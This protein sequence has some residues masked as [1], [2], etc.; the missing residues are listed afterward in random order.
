MATIKMKV[1][2]L[3]LVIFTL[4]LCANRGQSQKP[5]SLI[6]F[7]NIPSL[8]N[9]ALS[10]DGTQLV[11]V[12][13][14]SNWEKNRQLGHI[15]RQNVDGTNLIQL[16]NSPEGES[17]PQWSP[18]GKYISFISKRDSDEENQ[19]YLI[20]NIG[21]E[22]KRLSDHPTDVRNIQ[23][24]PDA[25]SI[26]FIANEKKSR[27]EKKRDKLKDDVFAFDENYKH[28]HLWRLA[29]TDSSATRITEGEFS[30]GSYELSKDGGSITFS[31]RPSPLLDD[32][33]NSEI[34]TMSNNGQNPR[35]L[36]FNSIPE[37]A[38]KLSFDGK[39]IIFIAGVNDKFE[40]YYDDNLFIL[41]VDGGLAELHLAD[42]NYE[43]V[44]A[45]WAADG[46]GIFLLLNM[47][48]QHQLFKYNWTSKTI[49]QLTIG[50]HT[51]EQWQYDS[52]SDKHVFAINKW[53]NPGDL[54]MMNGADP[55][56]LL[57]LTNIYDYLEKEFALPKQESV[58]WIGADGTR[59]EGIL[60]YPTD[61]VAGTKYPL[62]VQ[63][64]GGPKS[65]DTY[66]LSKS[67]NSYHTVLTGKSYMVLRPNYRGSTGYGDDFLRDMVGNYFRN[68][69][70][71]VMAG[72][73]YLIAR[74]L[75][76]PDRLIK[77]GWSAGGHMTNKLITF[78]E[79][80]KAASSGA[81]AVNWL[82]MYAQSDVRQTRTPWFG[83]SPWQENAPIDRYWESS[84][85]KDI[86]KVK[87]PTLVIVGGNDVRVPSPQS[88]ELYRA[89]KSNNVPTHLFIAPREPHGWRELRHRLYKMNVEL[90]WFAK[91]ALNAAYTREVHPSDESDTK[92]VD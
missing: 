60:Y 7:L 89:L 64:H 75:A 74:G 77:M 54:Y 25:S 63:T 46:A 15:W 86:H 19:A 10:P 33:Y 62:V 8:G 16:T 81:G 76:D 65:S 45:E 30:I 21:G 48:V 66:G 82:G 36:T 57:R 78:T 31:K 80:F 49:E 91:Y 79:R 85:L 41:P 61:Y 56:S 32:S 4:L 11:Y 42:L 28:S 40:D 90:E 34:W 18:D 59:V 1:L 23:W 87:T 43:V 6:D 73:D 13:S 35:Q 92:E 71:D 29:L 17:N 53:N 70:L 67:Q 37:G 47:G 83:G 88:V 5:M 38:P 58:S 20:R 39:Q 55:Q 52:N 69:H 22:A 27:E 26:Y 68:S 12:L 14:E 51:I 2:G 72:V 84:P 9:P 3:G 50:D 24:S 44:N